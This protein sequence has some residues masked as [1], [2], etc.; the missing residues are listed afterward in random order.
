MYIISLKY[1]NYIFK[2]KNWLHNIP[3]KSKIYMVIILNCILIIFEGSS[4]YVT[5]FVL[6]LTISSRYNYKNY[7][8]NLKNIALSTLALYFP[9]VIYQ[10]IDKTQKAILTWK[11]FSCIFSS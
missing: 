8:K 5:Y 6:L 4:L 10:L 7:Y 1:N 2:P 11:K 3:S 9:L